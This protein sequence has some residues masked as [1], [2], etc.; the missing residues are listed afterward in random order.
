ML[1]E[2]SDDSILLILLIRIVDALSNYGNEEHAM[3][4]LFYFYNLNICAF[5]MTLSLRYRKLGI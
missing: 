5:R 3:T 4:Q 1:E 2:K